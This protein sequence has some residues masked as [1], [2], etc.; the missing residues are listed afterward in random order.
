MT[1][2][3]G[4]DAEQTEQVVN[5]LFDSLE[6]T[7]AIETEEF[8]VFLDHIPIAIVTSKLV[9]GDQRIVYAN[10]AYEALTGQACQDIYGRGWSILELSA[11]K[12]TR[13]FRSAPRWQRATISSAPSAANNRS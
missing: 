4:Q 3:E 8:R 12:T 9:R 1:T 5:D 13:S 6:M 2:P 11:W 10:N 7:Q